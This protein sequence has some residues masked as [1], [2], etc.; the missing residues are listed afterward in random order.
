M[1]LVRKLGRALRVVIHD[2]EVQRSGKQFGV[3]IAVRLVLALG[4]SVQIAELIQ[5]YLG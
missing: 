4:G 2:P 1:R 3:K 5:K